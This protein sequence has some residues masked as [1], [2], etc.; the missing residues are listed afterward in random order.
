MKRIKLG[1]VGLVAVLVAG[2]FGLAVSV[3][4]QDAKPFGGPDSVKFADDLWTELLLAQL[5]GANAI[6]AFPYVG[7]AP[8]GE[9]LVTL[10]SVLTVRGITGAVIVKK[11]YTAEG[12]TVESVGNDP[13]QKHDVT[14]MFRREAGYDAD[15]KNWFWAKYL[16]D[17][18]IIKAPPGFLAGRVLKGMDAGCI[19]CHT[20]A[21]GGDMV[22]LNDRYGG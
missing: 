22:F 8:H 10:E 4:A 19:K 21:P 16:A 3:N 2:M 7:G 20:G 17:G 12:T 14:V 15:N 18:Q 1:L 13:T 6:R 9:I 11:N 5:V